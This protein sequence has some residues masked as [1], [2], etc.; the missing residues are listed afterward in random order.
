MNERRLFSSRFFLSRCDCLV[1]SL[2]LLYNFCFCPDFDTFL[3]PVLTINGVPMPLPIYRGTEIADFEARCASLGK[4]GKLCA[5]CGFSEAEPPKLCL[6]GLRDFARAARIE[7][8]M[9]TLPVLTDSEELRERRE[10]RSRKHRRRACARRHVSSKVGAHLRPDPN[11]TS[12][13]DSYRPDDFRRALQ[14]RGHRRP[15]PAHPAQAMAHK[16]K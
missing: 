4:A 7:G 10:A 3:W 14:R 11:E 8:R 16:E 5:L 6:L 13:R 15:T 9:I 1:I 2:I 12:R